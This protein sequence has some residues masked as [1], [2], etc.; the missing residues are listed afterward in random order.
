MVKVYA[1]K[2]GDLFTLAV[3]GHA[4]GSEEVCAGVSA[5]VFALA[6]WVNEYAASDV[7]TELESGDALV[8]FRGESEAE[9]AFD[10]AVIGLKQIELG[11]RDSIRVDD[12]VLR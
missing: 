1:E 11:H 9:A 4:T 5:I 3:K 2:D 12:A 6:G 8:T 7:K 10:M